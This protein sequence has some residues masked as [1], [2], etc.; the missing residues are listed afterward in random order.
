M[1]DITVFME[2]RNKELAG[3]A[4]KDLKSIKKRARGDEPE[5]FDH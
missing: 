5:A 3:I 4:E 2:G 1:D